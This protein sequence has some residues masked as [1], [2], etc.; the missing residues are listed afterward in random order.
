MTLRVPVDVNSG[1]LRDW[2]RKIAVA[3][4]QLQGKAVL[5]DGAAIYTAVTISNP[6][7]QAEVQ[8]IADAL[9]AVSNRLK[10]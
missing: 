9:E 2:G 7:T 6:P 10:G 8:A 1:S 3:L 4:N 5:K